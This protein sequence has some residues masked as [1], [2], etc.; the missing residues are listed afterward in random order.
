MFAS[1]QRTRDVS[2]DAL[3]EALT[4]LASHL[5]KLGDARTFQA[6]AALDLSFSQVCTLFTLETSDHPL[7]VHELAGRLGLSVA[8][9]GRAVDALV[10]EGLVSRRE[11]QH[12]RRI[13][14]ISL[15]GAG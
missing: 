4:R 13:K 3:T 1:M 2:V 7:A 12:D 15:T 14:R 10:R 9:T 6:A 5:K 11:D 8:A